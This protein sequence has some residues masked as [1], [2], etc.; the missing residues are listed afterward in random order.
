[1]ALGGIQ[2]SRR[3]RARPVGWWV[4]RAGDGVEMKHYLRQLAPGQFSLVKIGHPDFDAKALA[5]LSTLFEHGL[6]DSAAAEAVMVDAIRAVS[7]RRRRPVIGPDCMAVV[8]PPDAPPRVEVRYH[9]L[10]EAR[11]NILSSNQA[12]VVPAAFTPFVVGSHSVMYP[13]VIAGPGL[14]QQIGNFTVTFEAPELPPG[15]IMAA[16]SQRRPRL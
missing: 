6:P 4:E 7:A 1:V 13:S 11:A 12:E 15:T 10:V 3:G 2:W 9:P 5:A 14:S 16:S 8:I